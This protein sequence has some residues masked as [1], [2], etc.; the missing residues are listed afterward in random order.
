MERDA[1]RAL[2]TMPQAFAMIA[3]QS[4]SDDMIIE[5]I[6]PLMNPFVAM[7]GFTKSPNIALAIAS[8]YGP[9]GHRLWRRWLESSDLMGYLRLY[10]LSEEERVIFSAALDASVLGADDIEQLKAVLVSVRDKVVY[11][12]LE[13]IARNH[14]RNM[15]MWI[16]SMIRCV[17]KC[18][19]T[20]TEGVMLSDDGDMIVNTATGSPAACM[21][22]AEMVDN[23]DRS[24]DLDSVIDCDPGKVSF[25]GYVHPVRVRRDA[26]GMPQRQ[27][28]GVRIAVYNDEMD[29]IHDRRMPLT[30]IVAQINMRMADVQPVFAHLAP[31]LILM[32]PWE[33]VKHI[34]WSMR[35]DMAEFI[36]DWLD[37]DAQPAV[38]R[39][40]I[41]E[42]ML[43]FYHM[44][45][46]YNHLARAVI[47]HVNDQDN[48]E[49]IRVTLPRHPEM[50]GIFLGCAQC[51]SDLRD[52]SSMCSRCEQLPYCNQVCANAHWPEHKRECGKK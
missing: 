52:M 20:D 25:T 5:N 37:M 26:S 43:R 47:N 27:K 35:Q 39:G 51:G 8:D 42:R 40:T 36:D 15:Y 48:A 33:V 18:V 49:R 22:T 41:A 9:V 2:L 44:T 16:T 7:R 29:V 12:L 3:Q 50:P 45:P 19:L 1:K 24:Y 13:Q 10:D 32:Q 34:V 38:E 14:P 4:L 17:A 28:L 11:P 23:L 46:V 21:M 6:L 31:L 30:G